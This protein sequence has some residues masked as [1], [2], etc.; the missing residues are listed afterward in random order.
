NEI[1]R[2][3][4]NLVECLTSYFTVDLIGVETVAILGLDVN[5]HYVETL[6]KDIIM[7]TTLMMGFGEN[8]EIKKTIE[9][10]READVDCLTLGQYMQPTKTHLKVVEYVTPEKFKFWEEYGNKA[11]FMYTA[12]GLSVRSS[13]KSYL[14]EVDSRV[15]RYYAVIDCSFWVASFLKK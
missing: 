13:Y 9:D 8:D 15:D 1:R 12:S 5:A 4:T 6:N 7:K 2:R 11:C 14:T 3:S 10:L